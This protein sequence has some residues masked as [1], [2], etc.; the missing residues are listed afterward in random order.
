MG[1]TDCIPRDD[2]FATKSNFVLGDGGSGQETGTTKSKPNIKAD[3]TCANRDGFNVWGWIPMPQ[4]AGTLGVTCSWSEG[5]YI[6]EADIAMRSDTIK[7]WDVW[8][9]PTTCS[10][11]YDPISVA[12]HEVGHFLGLEHVTD[13][14]H[15]E[16]TMYPYTYPCDKRGETCGQGNCD[17]LMHLYP[18]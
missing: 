10:A 8:N 16:L 15:E 12:T 2:R 17:G 7:W 18:R 9:H 6:R 4:S 13:P 14:S 1:Y 11:A 3:A 5:K